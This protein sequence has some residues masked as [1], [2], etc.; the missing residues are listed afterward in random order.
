MTGLVIDPYFSAT[1]LAWLLRHVK[2]LE[3]RAEAGEVCFGTVDSF[4]LFKLTGGRL[5]ATDATN[6]ARTMLY[7]IR[8]GRW[9]ERLLDRLSVPRAVLPEVR[10][11]QSDYG[12]TE[13]EHLGAALPITGRCRRPAGCRLRSGLLQA[14]HAEG[15]LRHRLFRARQYRRGEG[16]LRHAHAVDHFSSA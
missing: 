13:P 2:G 12:V 14:R 3:A 7:D 5:H 8:S 16:G 9:D 10:D 11:S 15:D 1:K 6:A 4:L